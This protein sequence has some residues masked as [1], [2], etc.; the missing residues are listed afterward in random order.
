MINSERKNAGSTFALFLEGFGIHK[1][2]LNR[3]VQ[4]V[5]YLLLF[6]IFIPA[7]YCFY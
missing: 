5:I 7:L 2:Y 1:F 3:P 6:W 4:E